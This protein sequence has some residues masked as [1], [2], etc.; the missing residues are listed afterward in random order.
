MHIACKMSG[1]DGKLKPTT[2]NGTKKNG[3]ACKV[4]FNLKMIC[5]TISAIKIYAQLKNVTVKDWYK[6]LFIY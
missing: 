5:R 1:N 6:L 4:I 2:I 3:L